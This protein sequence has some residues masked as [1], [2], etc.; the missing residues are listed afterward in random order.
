MSTRS[1]LL[2]MLF[3]AVSAASSSQTQTGAPAGTALTETPADARAIGWAGGKTYTYTNTAWPEWLATCYTYGFNDTIPEAINGYNTEPPDGNC[4]NMSDLVY[5]S[6]ASDLPGGVVV[7]TGNTFYRYMLTEGGYNSTYV[8]VRLS[9]TFVDFATSRPLPVDTV[10]GYLLM[11]VTGDFTLNAFIE[12]VSPYGA[13]DVVSGI[14]RPAITLFDNLHTDPGSSICTSFDPGSFYS[15]SVNAVSSNTGPYCEEEDISLS[16]SGGTDYSWSGP[17][18]YV[19]EEQNPVILDALSS[20]SGD[21]IVTVLD[22]TAMGCID[23]SHTNVLVIEDVT[24]PVPD[25]T[26]LDTVTGECAATVS[27]VP[28][29]TDNCA[30]P[31][32]GTTDDPLEYNGQGT[33]T[34]TWTYDDGNDNLTTQEQTVIVDDTT[35]PV[36]DQGTLDDL[37]GECS[38]TVSTTPTATDNCEGTVNGTTADPL[39]YTEEGTYTVTWTYDDGNGNSATQEQTVII[40]DVTAPVPDE[41]TLVDLTGECNVTVSTTPTATD[42]CEGAV[43]GTTTDPLEYSEQGTFTITW[44]YDDGNGNSTTQEQTVVVEDVTDPQ[45]SCIEDQVRD[46]NEGETEYLVQGTEF[47]PASTGDNC[48]I[49]T[50]I[51][52]YSGSETLYNATFD[53]GNETVTWT[54]TDIAGNT[55]S[56]SF[57]VTVNEYVVSL[58]MPHAAEMKIFP[59][60]TDGFIHVISTENHAEISIFTIT[61]IKVLTRELPGEVSNLDIS[62]LEEGLYI[63]QVQTNDNIFTVKVLKE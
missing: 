57:E 26:N 55:S 25:K 39:E 24:G 20:M 13:L 19:S 49:A 52:D 23:T 53:P 32:T 62:S 28:T 3:F 11:K 2:A 35:A 37:T 38:V 7:Y 36:P 42:N 51:N 10:N 33:F 21:Y 48:A 31:V 15:F 40:D 34:V 4:A 27:D 58:K 44:T 61:G 43:N 12:A 9:L 14:W 47:D 45:V 18:G 60:P 1:T 46:L 16:S 6:T 50:V 41:G 59:N 22:S 5:N 17:D 29:A 56:C 30:G 63:I 8:E 54:I